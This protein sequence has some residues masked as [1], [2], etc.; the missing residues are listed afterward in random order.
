[1]HLQWRT[2]DADSRR[3]ACGS[4]L[5]AGVEAKPT[6]AVPRDTAPGGALLLD[7]TKLRSEGWRITFAAVLAGVVV[8]FVASGIRALA[9]GVHGRTLA[10]TFL[11]QIATFAP[12]LPCPLVPRPMYPSRTRDSLSIC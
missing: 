12:C 1:M 6:G 4:H 11:M 10:G 7:P 5:D 3:S 9:P 8:A 2:G